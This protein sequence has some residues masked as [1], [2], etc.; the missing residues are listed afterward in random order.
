MSEESEG[1]KGKGIGCI[2]IIL[3]LVCLLIIV[4]IT[5]YFAVW[6]VPDNSAK[7]RKI[8]KKVDERIGALG[9]TPQE[10]DGWTDYE[11]AVNGLD[12]SYPE[13]KSGS[14]DR[15][16]C[17]L[18]TGGIP[19]DKASAVTYMLDGNRKLLDDIDKGFEKNIVFI[20]DLHADDMA[21]R[22]AQGEKIDNLGYYL[23]LEGDREANPRKKIKRYLEAIHLTLRSENAFGRASIAS[24][25]S[26][27]RLNN[28]LKKGVPNP[29]LYQFI[30]LEMDRIIRQRSSLKEKMEM[31]LMTVELMRKMA[32]QMA[33]KATGALAPIAM[34]FFTRDMKA[35]ENCF[36]QLIES[37]NNSTT[38][39]FQEFNKLKFYPATAMK[40]FILP[41]LTTDFRILAA[42][43]IQLRGLKVLAA[44]KRFRAA[45][46]KYPESL[47]KLNL[48]YITRMP[49][50]PFSPNAMFRYRRISDDNIILYSI[51]PDLKDENAGKEFEVEEGS[52][53]IVVIGGHTY[54][55]ESSGDKVEDK[56]G[57]TRKIQIKK[58]GETGKIPKKKKGRF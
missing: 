36:L 10:D 28:L 6:R 42:E 13:G 18:V 17:S 33:K 21:K 53:D 14:F 25:R 35:T 51:G 39:G 4:L 27:K 24:L 16:L 8:Q 52:G 26:I 1:T 9:Q 56:A 15:E 47:D 49:V 34:A 5:A 12:L 23:I 50:D 22:G 43:E 30:I 48:Q 37:F 41:P 2:K 46:G 55:K 40:T 31:Q 44:L 45:K 54:N 11:K 29:T 7:V 3:I 32:P 20:P 38:Q 19:K 58:K 57:K